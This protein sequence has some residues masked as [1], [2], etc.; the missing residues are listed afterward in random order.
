VAAKVPRLRDRGT[1]ADKI[2]FTPSILPR[3][4]R[5]ARSVEDLRPW[6]YLKGMST[7]DFTEALALAT[8]NRELG[9]WLAQE[10]AFD[11]SF[12]NAL[13]SVTL[14]ETLR[15][16]ILG[17]LAGERGDFPQAEDE[18]DAAMIG[19]L[20]SVQPPAQLRRE[21]L[22]AMERSSSAAFPPKSLWWR[23]ALP[24]AAAAGVALAFTL[25]QNAGEKPSAV[26]AGRVP[27]DV[28]Q[29]GFIR[30]YQSPLFSLDETRDDHGELIDHLKSRKLPCPGCLPPGLVGVKSIGC[31]ELVIDGKRGSLVCF[32][33]S[34]NGVVH[35]VIFRREDVD[36]ELPAECQLIV[37]RSLATHNLFS[38]AS[39]LSG[40]SHKQF[41]TSNHL[42][43]IQRPIANLARQQLL[44]HADLVS[45]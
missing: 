37:R 25:T 9:E 33:E 29:A 22:T 5:K 40:R 20:A 4:L 44:S 19:A 42:F 17:C 3:Y 14:P 34:E 36:G 21:I 15:H 8:E 10:R 31:R 13:A 6:H 23:L 18:V 2:S 39:K 7:G 16:D 45:N 11:A 28:V 27:V 12:A 32:D 43:R 26:N 1:G 30:A 41:A 35:L 24:T 38:K